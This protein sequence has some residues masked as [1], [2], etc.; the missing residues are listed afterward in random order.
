MKRDLFQ[1]VSP[2]GQGQQS[3]SKQHKEAMSLVNRVS[4]ILTKVQSNP[5]MYECAHDPQTNGRWMSHYLSDVVNTIL[6]DIYHTTCLNG[7]EA[8][9]ELPFEVRSFVNQA[10]EYRCDGRFG[11]VL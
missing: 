1:K 8:I 6:L 4:R 11:D 7:F 9:P 3:E 5:K 10:K 2:L